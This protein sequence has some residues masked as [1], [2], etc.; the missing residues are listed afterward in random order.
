M[1]FVTFPFLFLCLFIA[2]FDTKSSGL[3]LQKRVG[4]QAKV[5]LIFKV[6]TISSNG[7]VS[8]FGNMLRKYKLDELPQLCNIL[9]GQMSFVG[10]RPDLEGF[11]DVLVG[12]DRLILSIRP[13]L[14]CPAS[15][16]YKNEEAMLAKQKDP[17]K[18][19]KEVIWRDKVAMNI[20]YI[21]NWSFKRDIACLFQSIF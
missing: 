2:T 8:V 18:Y 7:T 12:N 3:F 11:A 9:L 1:L 4:E 15:I 13:G 21:Q 5:F 6:R 10:P 14:T 16:K 19:N 17:E 20:E